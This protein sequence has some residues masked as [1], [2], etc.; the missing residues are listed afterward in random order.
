MR[1]D[2]LD[3]WRRACM[4]MV[5]SV[6]ESRSIFVIKESEPNLEFAKSM[7]NRTR[8]AACDP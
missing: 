8:T 1:H 7:S 2:A 6:P 5:I 3:G 4:Q